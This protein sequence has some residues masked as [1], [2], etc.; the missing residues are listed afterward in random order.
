MYTI[1]AYAA[2]KITKPP[3]LKNKIKKKRIDQKKTLISTCSN[4]K[5]FKLIYFTSDTL[6]NTYT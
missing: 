5:I 6:T 1:V 4:T 2:S 3:F